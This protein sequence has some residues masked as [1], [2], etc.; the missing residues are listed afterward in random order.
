M[1]PV[2]PAPIPVVPSH[3]PV[4]DPAPAAASPQHLREGLPR[5]LPSLA[6]VCAPGTS[7]SHRGWGTWGGEGWAG[8]EGRLRSPGNHWLGP[9]I[10]PSN[11]GL[12]GLGQPLAPSAWKGPWVGRLGGER[13]L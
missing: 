12:R 6:K 2:R 5:P 4:R 7:S 9:R 1:S 10:L 8:E 11:R 3:L 13:P